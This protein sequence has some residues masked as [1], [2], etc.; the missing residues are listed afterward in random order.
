MDRPRPVPSPAGFV[1]KKG[2]NIFSLTS[3][4]MPMPLSRILI[5]PSHCRPSAQGQSWYQAQWTDSNACFPRLTAA[6]TRRGS[7][8]QTKGFGSA[9]VSATKRLTA[10]FRS[11]V[12]QNYFHDQNEQY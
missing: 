6:R 12:L 2:L 1:V 3:G 11:N 5:V 4:G 8:V 9:L 7:A 10:A